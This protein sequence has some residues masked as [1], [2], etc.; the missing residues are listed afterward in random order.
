ML[1]MDGTV[2]D[3]A[4]DNFMWLHHVPEQFA[5]ARGMAPDEARRQLYAKFEEML[6]Q[7]EWYC[8]DHWSEFLGLD[9][10]RLHREQHHRIGY[11]PGAEDFLQRVVSRELRLL[12]VTNSHLEVLEIKHEATGIKAHF[13]AIHSS[14]E[15]GAPKESQEFWHAL[16]Q[17]EG[18]DPATTLFI[19]DTRRVLDSA[20]KFGIEQL[21]EVTHPDTSAPKREQGDYTT[22]EGLKDLL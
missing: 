18:F 5:E 14:H 7:L 13:D 9:V 6:G 20:A 10:A 16:Q 21:V 8:L 17:A 11:L 12:L 1:D 22:V 4:F 19:D 3:L 15:F 2:L